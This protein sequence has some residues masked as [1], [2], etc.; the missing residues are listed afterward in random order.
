LDSAKRSQHHFIQSIKPNSGRQEIYNSNAIV[1]IL[2]KDKRVLGVA[3]KLSLQV[4]YNVGA[5]DVAG[6][7]NGVDVVAENKLFFF[8]N[9]VTAGSYLDLANIPNSII[10]GKSAAAKMM[11][12]IGDVI[13]VTT[14]K[15]D[16][17]P[18]KV[19]GFFQSGLND[20]DKVQSYTS[21]ATAQKLLG[22]PN[23][24]ITDL[25]V[26]LHDLNIAPALAKEYKRIFNIAI[27]KATGFSG[28]DVKRIFLSIALTIGLVGGL[29]GLLFGLIMSFGIDQIPF[30][31]AAL[32]TI[33]TYPINYNPKFYLIGIVFSLITTYLAGLF[34]ARKASKI[35]PVVIIRGK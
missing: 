27:L 34:P 3:P 31:T 33:K 12:N 20:V 24:Y 18:L 8:S 2:K 23:S 21:I 28:A 13:Q 10:L 15:G 26:K 30:N 16:R 25:Q 9:Y 1:Q 35:D 17:M 5:I 4:F 19:V 32:P 22:K 11:V 14:S 29:A 6:A 7:I